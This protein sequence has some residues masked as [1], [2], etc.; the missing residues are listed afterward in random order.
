MTPLSLLPK[1]KEAGS[2]LALISNHAFLPNVCLVEKMSIPTPPGRRAKIEG[3]GTA[4]IIPGLNSMEYPSAIS[5]GVRV[6]WGSAS[7]IPAAVGEE[8][9][10]IIP[11]RLIEA[12]R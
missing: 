6:N 7:A 5:P 2:E 8:E 10:P 3:S 1:G 11:L 9:V 4:V 12:D